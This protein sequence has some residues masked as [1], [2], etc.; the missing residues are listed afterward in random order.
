MF[1]APFS[2][3]GRIRRKEYALSALI[4]LA[5]TTIL[6]LVMNAITG[7]QF[8]DDQS[9]IT[10]IIFLLPQVIFIL[11][12]GAKRCH[13]RGSSAWY[14]LIPFYSLWLFFADSEYGPNQYG[15]NPKGIGNERFSFEPEDAVVEEVE[16][17]S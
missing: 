11:A 2:F 6:Q 12:Q 15:D 14:Q 5:G 17:E 13:D 9:S 3:D 16:A 10:Y 7:G 1:K 8:Y 4:Y